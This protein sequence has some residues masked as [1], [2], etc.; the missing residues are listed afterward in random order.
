M[1]VRKKL[2]EK[3]AKKRLPRCLMLAPTRELAQQVNLFVMLFVPDIAM[4]GYMIFICCSSKLLARCFFISLY[5]V[6]D[7]LC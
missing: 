3:A 5:E 4:F 2:G 1:H 6:I 7:Q